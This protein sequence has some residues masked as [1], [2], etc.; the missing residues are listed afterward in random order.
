MGRMESGYLFIARSIN[1]LARQHRVR[2]LH[3]VNNDIVI[4]MQTREELRNSNGLTELIRVY[5]NQI[6]DFQKE[7]VLARQFDN[8]LFIEE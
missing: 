6:Y 2:R 4:E 1:N 5:N 8:L 7:R 3:E